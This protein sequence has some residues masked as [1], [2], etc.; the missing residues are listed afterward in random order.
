ME[1]WTF[2]SCTCEHDPDEHDFEHCETDGCPCSGHWE[3]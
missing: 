3:E 2:V 1:C